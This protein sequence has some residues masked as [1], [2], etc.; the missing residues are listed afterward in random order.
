V[1]LPCWACFD[2]QHLDYREGV[3]RRSIPSVSLEAGA[4]LGWTRYVD[5][6]IGIDS[7][8][9]SAPGQYALDY[10]NM[11]GAALVQHVERMLGETK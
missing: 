8:G 1:A 4:T 9:I 3:L 2:D 11:T 5:Q 10:F 7:F 6:A